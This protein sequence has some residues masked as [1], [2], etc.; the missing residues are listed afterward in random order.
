MKDI[1]LLKCSIRGYLRFLCFDTFC[2]VFLSYLTFICIDIGAFYFILFIINILDYHY[3][4]KII[5]NK[6]KFEI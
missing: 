6:R 1:F 2:A 3:K 5:K 4:N